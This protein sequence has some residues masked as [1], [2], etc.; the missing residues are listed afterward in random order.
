MTPDL[1]TSRKGP[2]LGL[3]LL[4]LPAL[5]VFAGNYTN[6]FS[7]GTTGLTIYPRP[8]TPTPPLVRP[9]GGNP[10]GYFKLTDAENGAGGTVIF[11][12]FEA[13]T[14]VEA[15]DFR[16]DARVGAGTNPPADGFSISFV[17]PGDDLLDDGNG[18]SGSPGGEANLPEE[19]SKTGLAIGFDTWDSGSGDVVG[20]SV[21]LDNVTITQIP[22]DTRN[23]S[24]PADATSLET[25]P[26]GGG[27]AAITWQPFRANLKADGN[28][29]VY[30]KGVKVIDNLATGYSPSPGQIVFAA[31]TG[32]ANAAFHF[33]NLSLSTSAVSKAA[34]STANLTN[35]GFDIKIV[36]FGTTSQFQPTTTGP[37]AIT[38]Q[39][40][41]APVTLEPG[42]VSKAGNTTTITYAPTVPF[43]PG[44]P[45]TFSV[46]GKDQIGATVVGSGTL[47]APYFPLVINGPEG[48]VGSWGLREWKKGSDLA[49]N[50]NGNRPLGSVVTQI[51]DLNPGDPGVTDLAS[52]PVMNHSDP[53]APGGKGNFNNEIPFPSNIAAIDD[54]NL[55]GIGKTKIVVP[56]P[57]NYTFAVHSDDGAGLRINGGPSG[58]TSR[59]VNVYGGGTEIDAGDPQTAVFADYTGD[60]N[61]HAVYNFTQAGT[62]DVTFVAFEGGGGGYWEL[63]WAPGVFQNDRDTNLWTLVG[64]P[65]DPAVPPTVPKY[66]TN[67]KTP[68][69]VAGKFGVR[70][71]RGATGVD[72]LEKA[73]NFLRDTTRLPSDDD[74]QTVE[75]LVP[76]INFRDPQDGNGG[77]LGHKEPF[78]GNTPS[79]ED[80]VVTVAR[81]RITIPTTSDY[82]FWGQGDDGFMLRLKGINGAPNPRFKRA[83]QGGNEGAG[84]FEMSN[85]N[86]LFYENGTGNSNTRGIVELAAGEYDVEY[87]HW[88]G[89]GGYWFELIA[90]QGSWPHGAEPPGGWQAVG[91]NSPATGPVPVPGLAEPGWTVES[92]TPGRPEFTFSI[93]GAEA[94][95]DATLA[96]AGAPA[97]KN[98]VYDDLNFIDPEDGNVGGFG[99]SRPWPLN[100][101]GGDDNFGVRA[102]GTLNITEAGE[103]LLGFQGDDGGYMSI[104]GAGNPFFTSIFETNHPNDAVI[105]EETPGSG[106][107]NLIRVQVGTGNSRTI[108]RTTLAVGTYQ[109]KTLVYEG[110]GGSWWEVIGT[111]A[112]GDLVPFSLLAKGSGSSKPDPDGLQ[113]TAQPQPELQVTNF[114][115]DRDT[116]EY[117]FTFDSV[118][119]ATYQMQY[120]IGFQA[121]GAPASPLKWNPVPNQSAESATSFLGQGLSTTRRGSVSALLSS[122]GGQLPDD[123]KVFFRVKRLP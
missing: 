59:F 61:I 122:S 101:G 82:T 30:W 98:S 21:K 92:S 80:N 57:G 95:I 66:A 99:N 32:G 103:Y 100:T 49:P 53:D 14:A 1:Y 71:Y 93:A 18:F 121:E 56:A 10:D 77:I 9:T 65:A 104:N 107:T 4:T 28:L 118:F 54:N 15:F 36:D 119:G 35:A 50:L 115:Y 26:Q 105:L 29:D 111:K 113:L 20:F 16:V 40:D 22:V 52:V 25:G 45:H 8:G 42:N 12:N 78:V 79:A 17:R 38:M 58:N 86:E 13:G 120:T 6:D 76:F 68:P 108:V 11:P 70:A 48:A 94:A 97:A 24:D 34:L 63:A 75:G 102:T 87:I 90:A 83:T 117:F 85:P 91:Y 73:S 39:V 47:R 116:T 67:L 89:G 43:D 123:S 109:L 31:R 62:Y 3:L 7:G 112:A 41:G 64:N 96:D 5:P 37:N 88:E 74:G 46:T 106:I 23:P 81:A 51:K 60:S 110:G 2:L 27:I 55:V 84:R 33:D 114:T 72:N 19:G 44:S 69:G